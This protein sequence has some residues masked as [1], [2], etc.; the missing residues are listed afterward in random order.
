[1]KTICERI[2]PM[3][4]LLVLC[5]TGIAIFTIHLYTSNGSDAA[6]AI[7]SACVGGLVP[8]GPKLIDSEEKDQHQ[9]KTAKPN[10]PNS[11]QPPT[12]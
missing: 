3:L 1:M 7:G 8:L 10:Q 12:P 6:L 9:D 5:L 4:G 2:R 11:S